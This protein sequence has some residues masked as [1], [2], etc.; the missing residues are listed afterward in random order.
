MV[1]TG[2]VTAVPGQNRDGSMVT[3]DDLVVW[4]MVFGP[5]LGPSIVEPQELRTETGRR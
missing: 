2:A 4:R 3:G 1:S 5:V